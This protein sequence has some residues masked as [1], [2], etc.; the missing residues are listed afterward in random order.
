MNDVRAAKH[1]DGSPAVTDPL[2]KEIR[3]LSQAISHIEDEQEYIM[4]REAAH[5][6][7][8]Y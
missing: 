5:R 2:E 1:P 4:M 6:D 3:K 8:T 7:S